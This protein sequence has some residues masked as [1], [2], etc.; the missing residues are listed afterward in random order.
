M[1]RLLRTGSYAVAGVDDFWEHA[2]GPDLVSLFRGSAGSSGIIAEMTIKLHPWPGDAYL[3]EPAAGRPCIRTYADDRYDQADPPEKFRLYWI[4]FPDIETQI[5]ALARDMP[6]RGSASAS[7]PPASTMCTTVP[8]PRTTPSNGSRRNFSPPIICISS[9]RG[10]TS[11]QQLAYEEKVI[12]TIAEKLRRYASSRLITSRRCL[13]PCSRGIL[14]ASGMCAAT[15][16]RA[17]SILIPGSAAGHRNWERCARKSGPSAI[18]TIG[19][20]YVTDRGGV[21][22]TPFMYASDPGG[23]NF[24]TEADVYPNGLDPQALQQAQQLM[25]FSVCMTFGRKI[26]PGVTGFGASFE[27]FTTLFPEMGPM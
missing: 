1:E 25:V 22:D 15:G 26:G 19:E 6:M 11:E 8:Q 16:C 14:T 21:D 23:R 17:T 10:F 2:P 3:P 4:E 20:T 13:K 27:P 24:F 7:M 9:A 5:Q 18:N 12:K